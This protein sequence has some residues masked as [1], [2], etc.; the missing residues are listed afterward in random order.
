MPC[1]HAHHLTS[2]ILDENNHF[3]LES[4]TNITTHSSSSS[5]S[6]RFASEQAQ[7]SY[8]PHLI[9][10]PTHISLSLT[11]N[12]PQKIAYGIVKHTFKKNINAINLQQQYNS[13]STENIY[14]SI[15]IHAV[16]LQID[17]VEGLHGRPVEYTYDGKEIYVEWVDGWH[18]PTTTGDAVDEREIL[19]KYVIEDPICGLHFYTGDQGVE[20]KVKKFGVHAISDN[21]TE[22]C[23]YWLPCVDLP[24]VRTTLEF[25]ITA[26]S[27]YTALANGER[28]GIVSH[29]ENGTA[30]TSYALTKSLCP[31]YL[32]CVA[33][34][35]LVEVQDESVDGMEVRY[36]APKGFL[37]EWLKLSF[38]R[39]P[40][41][42]RWLQKK[43][44]Y[45]FPWPKY[46]QIISP[47]ILGGAMENISLVT[48][49]ELYALDEIRATE[50][51]HAMDSVNIHEMAHT[52][53][54]D[55]LVMRHFEHAWLKESWAT[56]IESCWF[57]DHASHEEF[58]LDL[59]QKGEAYIDECVG[60]YY[61]P[62][63]CKVYDSSW[64]LFDRHLYP[65]YV[66]TYAGKLVETEDFKRCLEQESKINLTQFFD[67]WIYGKGYPKIKA[68]YEYHSD[69][70]VV[71]IT[72]E[73]TQVD[74]GNGIPLFNIAVEV[75]VI[76][77][78]GLVHTGVGY[79]N[80]NRKV[81]S[82]FVRMGDDAK[83]NIVEIDPRGKVL[84]ELEFNP[85]LDI[86]GATAK[87]GR[88]I[89][90]R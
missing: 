80:T 17:S 12:I 78:D 6:G 69:K 83:P 61:R 3:L 1:N 71:E 58:R 29:P 87:E 40:A 75:D 4:N 42:V 21:E 41:M 19:I 16:S 82:V 84:I 22:K 70:K 5:S 66:H 64:E 55:L 60:K 33:V 44:G 85:G 28:T 51:L 59:I 63:V 48:Y 76:D 50:I 11:F 86:L 39:T 15:R 65:D 8:A 27:T 57:E 25:H 45:K 52:Y 43:V 56:Y 13:P 18:S 47:E 72:M 90:S 54:G 24:S 31:S 81:V 34:G 30:T 2:Q 77:T 10:E 88:D 49:S 67:Q 36:F 68:T 20:G 74:P 89:G 32:I 35:D 79:F 23:R 38:D 7:P 53:F 26:P 37:E 46:Y 9:I 62:I 14:S 73:Q